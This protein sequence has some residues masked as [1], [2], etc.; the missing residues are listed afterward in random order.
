MWVPVREKD[1]GGIGR[2]DG[3]KGFGATAHKATDW[4]LL[5]IF[6]FPPLGQRQMEA[7]WLH[8]YFLKSG[9]YR[10][11]NSYDCVLLL[12]L[13]SHSKCKESA[14]WFCDDVSCTYYLYKTNTW[15]MLDWQKEVLKRSPCKACVGTRVKR[16]FVHPHCTIRN[17]VVVCGR[18]GSI[19]KG[20]TRL[21]VDLSVDHMCL[22]WNWWA[23]LMYTPRP[24]SLPP[25]H[26]PIHPT[27]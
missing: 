15:K 27:A 6:F 1:G 12:R 24:S 3:K 2:R 14:K 11:T 20:P 23:R 9:H 10:S 5:D 17:D 22:Q 8:S 7:V 19:F 21:T 18:D 26:P 4:Q 13:I 25:T 16:Q